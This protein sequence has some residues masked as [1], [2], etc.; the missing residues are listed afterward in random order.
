MGVQ[1]TIQPTAKEGDKNMNVNTRIDQTADRL[2]SK[3]LRLK[4]ML[5]DGRI[6]P[7][8]VRELCDMSEELI[9]IA[10]DVEDVALDVQA[11]KQCLTVGRERTPNRHLQDRSKRLDDLREQRAQQWARRNGH[12]GQTN[13]SALARVAEPRS[14]YS[15]G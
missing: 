6:D 9:D 1:V 4:D 10:D 15:A 2:V 7:D 5:K 8:E 14:E 12:Y 3:G 13:G 11:A